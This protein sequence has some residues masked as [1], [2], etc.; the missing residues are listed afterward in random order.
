MSSQTEAFLA[1]GVLIGV[2]LLAFMTAWSSLIV[3]PVYDA[4]GYDNLSSSNQFQVFSRVNQSSTEILGVIDSVGS[5]FRAMQQSDNAVTFVFSMFSLIG[6]SLWGIVRLLFGIPMLYI[7]L[8][9]DVS[10]L[11]KGI[12]PGLDVVVGIFLALLSIKIFLGLLRD[13]GV[14]K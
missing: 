11:F 5:N 9:S 2:A 14:I 8:L 7:D 4:S 10:S 12:L 3:N 1:T 6:T 13:F